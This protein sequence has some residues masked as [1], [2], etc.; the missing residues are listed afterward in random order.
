M[1]YTGKTDWKYDEVVTENDMNRIEKGVMVAHTELQDVKDTVAKRT[2]VVVV[3]ASNSS[4]KSKNGA[5]YICTGTD[6]YLTINAAISALPA[7]GG[8]VFLMAGTYNVFSSVESK[9]RSINLISNLTLEGQGYSTVLYYPQN[10]F[11]EELY[12]IMG[13]EKS[14]VT[15]KNLRITTKGGV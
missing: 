4:Q 3:A 6:D 1:A 14:H 2:A 8:K 10:F 5:D 13:Y 11:T 12:L 7:I 15:L 9:D